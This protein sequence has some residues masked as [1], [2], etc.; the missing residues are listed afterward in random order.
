MSESSKDPQTAILLVSCPDQPGIVAA[1]SAF[2]FENQGNIVDVDQH[3]DSEYGV[4]LMRVEWETSGFAVSRDEISKAIAPLAER[5]SMDWSLYFSD[6]VPRVALFVTRDNHCLYDLLSRHESGELRM[7]VPLI[8]SNREDLRPAAER[9]GIPF[10]HFPIT[11]EN[12]SDQEG[13]EIEL[14]NEHRVDLVVLAR[15]M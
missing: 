2:L 5:F 6:V 1:V 12:K 9:F 13:L 7:E 3:V 8:V 15:Y 11:Q 10:H 14:L 4:F